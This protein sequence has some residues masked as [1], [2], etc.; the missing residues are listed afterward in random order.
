MKAGT[1]APSGR[2]AETRLRVGWADRYKSGNRLHMADSPAHF[3]HTKLDDSRY[4]EGTIPSFFSLCG[5]GSISFSEAA[6]RRLDFVQSH[7]HF[8]GVKILLESNRRFSKPL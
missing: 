6:R 8:G 2:G 1:R 7:V 5:A 4:K 3:K